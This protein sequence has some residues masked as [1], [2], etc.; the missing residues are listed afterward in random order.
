MGSERLQLLKLMLNG[1]LVQ[2]TAEPLPSTV[3][4]GG[5]KL[6]L[7]LG[8]VVQALTR[9]YRGTYRVL[10]N[11]PVRKTSD[12]T[13]LGHIGGS[14]G[15]NVPPYVDRNRGKVVNYYEYQERRGKIIRPESK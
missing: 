10:P 15:W 11:K 12:L 9:G 4:F 8:N 5:D 13:H 14:L 2:S 1:S 7:T 3:H 6:G